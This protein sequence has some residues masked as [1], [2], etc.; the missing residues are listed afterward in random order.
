MHIGVLYIY[1]YCVRCVFI[2]IGV[3]PTYAMVP[4]ADYYTCAV[5]IMY[6]NSDICVCVCSACEAAIFSLSVASR[7]IEN[8][9]G[10]HRDKLALKIR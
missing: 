4:N 7:Y 6:N 9:R 5:Y 2:V 3:K 10:V 8:D 1:I